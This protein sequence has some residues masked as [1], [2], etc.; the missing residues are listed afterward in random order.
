MLTV[1][2]PELLPLI[3]DIPVGLIPLW[4]KNGERPKLVIKTTKETILAAKINQGFRIYAAPI[5][6]QGKNTLGF[7]SAFF[8]DEDEPL[9]I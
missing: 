7:L 4:L 3:Y 5:V 6:V 1:L 8:D 2:H 9:V